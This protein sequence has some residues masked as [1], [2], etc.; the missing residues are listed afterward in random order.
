MSIATKLA[1][2]LRR[3]FKHDQTQHDLDAELQAHLDLLTEEKIR[4]GMSPDQAR[5]AARIELGGF[6]QVKEQTR[7]AHAGAWID[8][9][10]RDIRYGARSLRKSPGFTIVTIATLALVIGANTAIFS[11]FYGLVFRHLPYKNPDRLVTVWMSNPKTGLEHSSVEW[12][13]T[14]ER[15]AKGFQAIAG[16]SSPALGIAPAVLWGT[17]ESVVRVLCT[18]Q[19]FQVLGA[20]PLLGRTFRRSDTLPDAPN[21]VILSTHFWK[22]HY[23]ASPE[24]IGK[25]LTLNRGGDREEYTIIGVMPD[26]VE[27]PFPLENQRP[28]FW[29]NFSYGDQ[30]GITLPVVAR[31]KPDVTMAQARAEMNM[32]AGQIAIELPKQYNG[33]VFGV[34]SLRSE[35]V[36]D[37]RSML[38]ILLAALA[39]VL[40]IGCANVSNLLLVRAFVREKEVAV[41]TALG[42]T[43]VILFRQMFIE[44][45]LLAFAGGAVGF[46]L[47]YWGLRGFVALLP[48]T[49]YVPRFQEAAID[50][51]VLGITAA[52]SMAA[53]L[54][55]GM[56]PVFRFSRV[57]LNKALK[58]S[59]LST[60][61]SA[62]VLRR[63]GSLLL[64]SEISLALVLLAG[65]VLLT[66]SFRKL[67]EANAR[68]RPTHLLTIDIGCRGDVSPR[69]SDLAT[70]AASLPGVRAVAL[71][72]HFPLFEYTGTFKA[73]SGNDPIAQSYQPAQ[74]HIVTASFFEMLG[75]R[76]QK[77]RWF[78]DTDTLNSPHVAVINQ[79]MA[80]YWRDTKPLGVQLMR[81]QYLERP[82][83]PL[84]IVGVVDEPLRLGSGASAKPSVYLPIAQRPLSDTTLVVRTEGDPRGLATTLRDEAMNVLPGHMFVSPA[85]TGEDLVSESTARLRFTM[86]LVSVF[87]AVALL[88]ALIGIYGLISYYTAQRTREIGIRMALGATPTSVL[89]LVLQEGMALILFGTVIGVAAAYAF[90]RGLASMLYGVHPG[91]A[92]ALLGSAV[93]FFAVASLAFYIPARRAMR[94]DPLVALRYE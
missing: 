70:R 82:P 67:F 30:D 77:G 80:L 92:T 69:Y 41:R 36:R 23:G 31:L 12:F 32:I 55:F 93:L 2:L 27:F 22:Q 91:D 71:A 26:S 79:A 47:A 24:A 94:V 89:K 75:Y 35:L 18:S 40:L 8:S 44:V 21:T 64:V 29:A 60:R 7:E 57:N 28:D 49:L 11:A 48:P 78:A 68:Y 14:F 5:R 84:T 58:T 4:A 20:T 56:M 15:E 90:G 1:N 50:L 61:G 86:M 19:F 43:R 33:E 38:W 76:L 42:A 9:L 45:L 46:L 17:E 73:L 87:S 88:L 72:N 37:V 25:I 34:S 85:Q 65:T 3:F 10:L 52:V 53:A 51:R 81:R 16:F 13:P 59:A 66:Q 54:L 39:F 74:M 83:D 63:P 62:S 6:E